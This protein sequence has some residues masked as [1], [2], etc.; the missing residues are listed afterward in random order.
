[1]KKKIYT[2]IIGIASVIII[3]TA[4][5]PY[6]SQNSETPNS[7]GESKILIQQGPESGYIEEIGD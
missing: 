6:Q 2:F 7:N 1:M 5:I 3:T 4:F